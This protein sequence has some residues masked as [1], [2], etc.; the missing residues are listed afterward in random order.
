MHAIS[1]AGGVILIQRVRRV[2][3]AAQVVPKFQRH[4]EFPFQIGILAA[5][6]TAAYAE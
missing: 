3:C 5:T 4:R 2:W 1:A 6:L